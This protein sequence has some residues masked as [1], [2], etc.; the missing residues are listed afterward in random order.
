MHTHIHITQKNHTKQSQR[1]KEQHEKITITCTGCNHTKSLVGNK[2]HSFE[3]NNGKTISVEEG[4]EA[5]SITFNHLKEDP[6]TSFL[7]LPVLA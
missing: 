6:N 7:H 1:T 3:Y 4:K 5:Y 2:H